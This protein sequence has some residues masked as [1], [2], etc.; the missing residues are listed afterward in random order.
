MTPAQLAAIKSRWER[1]YGDLRRMMDHA[2][3]DVAA[4]IEALETQTT[5]ALWD[6]VANLEFCLEGARKERDEALAQN[7]KYRAA[8]E[9]LRISHAHNETNAEYRPLGDTYGY[10]HLCHTKVAL[11]EDVARD[12]LKEGGE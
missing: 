9:E 7:A 6:T 11:N 4:L 10:C 2:R 3:E 1:P 5:V 8:L 12:A